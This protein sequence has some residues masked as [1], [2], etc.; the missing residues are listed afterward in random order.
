MDNEGGL[1][2]SWV[3]NNHHNDCLLKDMQSGESATV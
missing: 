1:N 3:Q 2:L